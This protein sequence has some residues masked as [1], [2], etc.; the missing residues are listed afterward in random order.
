M[1]LKLSMIML[2]SHLVVAVADH[3][4]KFDIVKGC[5]VDS[6]SAFDPNAGMEATIKR[7][8][9]DEKHSRDQLKAN[10]SSF[11]ESDRAM[12]ISAAVG[13]GADANSDPPSYVDLQTCLQDQQFAR[14]LPKE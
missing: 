7:C 3:L 6:A 2:G 10:W 11:S 1:L 4:P 8:T 14:K 12:C 9:D 13:D 5:K